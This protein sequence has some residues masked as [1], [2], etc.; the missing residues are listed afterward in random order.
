MI[1]PKLRIDLSG[2]AAQRQ[3]YEPG[4]MQWRDG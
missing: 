4:S 1:V 2:T 3:A